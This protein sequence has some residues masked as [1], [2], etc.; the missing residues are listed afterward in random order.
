MLDVEKYLK[1]KIERKLGKSIKR[2]FFFLGEKEFEVMSIDMKKNIILYFEMLMEKKSLLFK[3]RQEL[4]SFIYFDK[5]CNLIK[6]PVMNRT[7]STLMG[8]TKEEDPF[9]DPNWKMTTFTWRALKMSCIQKDLLKRFFIGNNSDWSKFNNKKR[10]LKTIDLSKISIE[11]YE[12]FS[13]ELLKINAGDFKAKQSLNDK[14]KDLKPLFS[15]NLRFS[16]FLTYLFKKEERIEKLEGFLENFSIVED[17][18]GCNNEKEIEESELVVKEQ[19]IDNSLEL[20]REFSEPSLAF[21]K[22]GNYIHCYLNRQ[23]LNCS[24]GDYIMVNNEMRKILDI[25]IRKGRYNDKKYHSILT[26]D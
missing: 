12:E 4:L 8:G 19:T 24:V 13:K 3:S 17:F 5:E 26:L 11:E 20:S 21:D 10:Y 15:S 2:D 9:Y 7:S 18:D 25:K 6:T 22:N 16:L 1:E 14:Y 23:H